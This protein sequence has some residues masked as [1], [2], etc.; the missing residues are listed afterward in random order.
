MK[1]VLV[2]AIIT[3][4]MTLALFAA[5]TAGEQSVITNSHIDVRGDEIIIEYH[6]E[7]YVHEWEVSE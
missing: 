3:I 1:K 7:T 5:F 2:W 4:A 6:G